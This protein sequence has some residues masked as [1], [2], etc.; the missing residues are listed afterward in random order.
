MDPPRFLGGWI[1]TTVP[2]HAE[3]AAPAYFD[4]RI[5]T[6]TSH[7]LDGVLECFRDTVELVRRRR[8][9]ST[10]GCWL[11]EELANG[12]HRANVRRGS[13]E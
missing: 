8:G 11:T 10:G 9:I 2:N 5:D 4:L 1:P 3:Q 13:D 6:V 7:K 12:S